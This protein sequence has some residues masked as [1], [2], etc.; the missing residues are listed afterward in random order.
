MYGYI[1]VQ[2]DFIKNYFPV[3]LAIWNGITVQKD[4]KQ[5]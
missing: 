4:L 2:S 3:Q 1:A 5:C